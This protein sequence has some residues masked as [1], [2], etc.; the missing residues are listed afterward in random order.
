[1]IKTAAVGSK[2][3]ARKAVAAFDGDGFGRE[4]VAMLSYLKIRGPNDQAELRMEVGTIAKIAEEQENDRADGS[5]YRYSQ[6]FGVDETKGT[7][8]SALNRAKM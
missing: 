5:L 3:S 7:S 1:M 8:N 6:V 4:L 2:T